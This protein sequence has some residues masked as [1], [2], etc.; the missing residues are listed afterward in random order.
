[1]PN[2]NGSLQWYDNAPSILENE[3][4]NMN[5]SFPDFKLAQHPDGQLYWQGAIE[6]G[7]LSNTKWELMAVYSPDYP[8]IECGE[9][10]RVY[11]M[12][13]SRLINELEWHPKYLCQDSNGLKYISISLALG[14]AVSYLSLAI[15]WLIAFELVLNG[16][17]SIEEFN[18]CNVI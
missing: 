6:V 10:V 15:K 3:M 8:N 18:S 13:P 1:M 2:N 12:E 4:K 17:L 16:D 5:I 9:R 7:V 14:S 11:L